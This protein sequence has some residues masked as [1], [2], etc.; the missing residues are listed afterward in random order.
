M[1]VSPQTQNH[2]L[3]WVYMSY[4]V[5]NKNSHLVAMGGHPRGMSTCGKSFI[6][7]LVPSHCTPTNAISWIYFELSIKWSFYEKISFHSV[8]VMKRLED[9]Q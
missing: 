3:I 4:K 5:I 7:F 2:Q 6:D 9:V 8:E 1:T